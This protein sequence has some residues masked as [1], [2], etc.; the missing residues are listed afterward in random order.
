MNSTNWTGW[1]SCP[2]AAWVRCTEAM[3]DITIAASGA[4]LVQSEPDGHA[5]ITISTSK[6]TAGVWHPT[7]WPT[8]Q[9]WRSDSSI[10]VMLATTAP[11][12]TALGIMLCGAGTRACLVPTKGI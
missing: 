7:D 3:T 10:L 1:G 4:Q 8:H 2:C 11:G 5:A 12:T 6:G 9:L